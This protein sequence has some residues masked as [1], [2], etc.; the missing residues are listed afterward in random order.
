MDFKTGRNMYKSTSGG[1][2]KPHQ[3]D[4]SSRVEMMMLGTLGFTDTL[5]AKKSIPMAINIL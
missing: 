1:H 5:S 4:D 2:R 3:N